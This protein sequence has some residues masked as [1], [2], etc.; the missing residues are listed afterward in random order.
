MSKS[1]DENEELGSEDV[2]QFLMKERVLILSE[3]VTPTKASELVSKLLFLDKKSKTKEI[4][5]YINSIGGHVESFFAIYD[6]MQQI[7]APIKTICL[8]EALSAAAGLLASGT[9]GRRFVSPNSL[10]MI[11]DI[12]VSEIYGS[13]G[14][15]SIQMNVLKKINQSFT[16][17]LAR[18]SGQSLA[19]LRKDCSKDYYM[20]AEE[21]LKYGLADKILEPK[22][23]IPELKK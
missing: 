4:T 13:M 23:K 21:S 1:K 2:G 19:K 12:Q 15:V 9:P 18:H 7:S 5:L 8:G 16:E 20:T 3:E 14:E 22:K 11:H 6:T 17:V 10:I